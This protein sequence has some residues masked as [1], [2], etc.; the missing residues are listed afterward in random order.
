MTMKTLRHVLILL[1]ATV[2]V[3]A[4]CDKQEDIDRAYT[5]YRYDIVTYLGQNAAG[6]VFE[7]LGRGDSAAIRLQSAVDISK[8]V[9]VNHRV[10]LRYDFASEATGGH[11]DIDVY[12]CSAIF[13]DS[14]RVT[15]NGLDSLPRHE[16]KLR[17]MWRTSE[18]INL[19]CQ[20]EY[21]GKSRTLMLVADGETLDKDTVHCYLAHDLRGEQGTFWRDCYASFNVGALWKRPSFHCLRVHLNDLTFPNNE[22]YDFTK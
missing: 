7:Y 16:V 8:D 11:R 9:K 19:H 12:S 2:L 14:L 4:S 18:F 17:S 3:M 15:A 1:T 6:A 13:S 21:T 10:L 22:Y 20:V 5:H